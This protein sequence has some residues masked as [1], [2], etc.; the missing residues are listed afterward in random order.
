MSIQEFHM[1]TSFFR[2]HKDEDAHENLAVIRFNGSNLWLDN[3]TVGRIR[4]SLTCLVEDDGDSRI[5]VD[6]G[7]VEYVSSLF[8]GLVVKLHKRLAATGRRLEIRNLRPSV[9]EVF[10][11]S[12][13]DRLLNLCPEENELDRSM[14]NGSGGDHPSVLVVDDDAAV[15]TLLQ[16]GLEDS[17]VQVWTARN[18]PIALQV[19]QR[20]GRRIALV[21]LDVIMPGWDGPR[22]L[23]ALQRLS[24]EIRCC[25]ITGNPQPYT[26]DDLL[27]MGA[28]RVF[29]KPF[30]L[31]ELVNALQQMSGW[32][33]PHKVA[34]GTEIPIPGA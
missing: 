24:P 16:R 23:Y 20:H 22:T 7:N 14:E 3:D 26:E 25:F 32:P 30:G 34:N 15:L 19:Y 1:N 11:V 18:G 6:L 17:G 2:L 10:T 8:L 29:R 33:L 27:R 4:N 12:N 9:Y 13:L 5:I 21:L 28:L 31:A